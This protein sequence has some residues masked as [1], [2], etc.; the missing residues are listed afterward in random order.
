MGAHLRSQKALTQPPHGPHLRAFLRPRGPP[1][2]EPGVGSLLSYMGGS[3]WRYTSIHHTFK[4]FS[5]KAAG[6]VVYLR[7]SGEHQSARPKYVS[8]NSTIP[9]ISIHS[10]Y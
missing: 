2:G 8:K 10:C 7:E 6:S 5:V 3:Y 1:L 4:W 9:Y